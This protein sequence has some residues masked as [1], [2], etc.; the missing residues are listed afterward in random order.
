LPCKAPNLPY[1]WP[2]PPPEPYLG[3]LNF[4][5]LAYNIAKVRIKKIPGFRVV[6]EAM[7]HNGDGG[8][9]WRK[10]WMSPFLFVFYLREGEPWLL[11]L[12]PSAHRP[13]AETEGRGAEAL[14]RC[15]VL[16]VV[17]YE[18][19]LQ[20]SLCCAARCTALFVLRHSC[21]VQHKC[22]TVV[23]GTYSQQL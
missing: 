2:L 18:V 22:C 21:A 19:L 20:G 4:F 23:R 9:S 1:Y 10:R 13:L 6:E 3:S 16:S 17:E 7:G 12:W 8:K 15:G 5:Q 11:W 14:V